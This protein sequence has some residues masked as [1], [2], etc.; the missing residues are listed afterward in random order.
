MQKGN[1][2][3]LITCENCGHD[4]Y[5]ES[6]NLPGGDEHC[7]YCENCTWP[8]PKPDIGTGGKEKKKAQRHYNG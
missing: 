1:Y 6:N 2:L 5:F 8:L 7:E 3:I 4:Q